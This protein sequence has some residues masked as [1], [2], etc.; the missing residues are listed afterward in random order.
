MPIPTTSSSQWVPSRRWTWS[1]G[2]SSTRVTSYIAEAPSYVGALSTFN[3][4]QA[5]VVHVQMDDDGLIPEHLRN[6]IASVRATGKRAKF[7]YTIPNFHNPAGVSL[8]LSRRRE[9]LEICEE[10]GAADPG[11]QPVRPAGLRRRPLAGDALPRPSVIYLGSFSKTF[12]P[13]FR[14]G[15]AVAPHAVRE[16]LVLAA[17]A[18]VLCPPSFSQLLCRVT[19]PAVDGQQ[20]KVFRELYRER[21]DA[22]LSALRPISR[23]APPGRARGGFY[24]WLTLPEGI[25]AKAMLPRAV[26][27][28][29]AYVSGTASTPTGSAAALRLSYCYPTPERIREGV[30]RLAGVIE[31][32][33]DVMRTFGTPARPALGPAPARNGPQTPS[34]HTPEPTAAIS[35]SPVRHRRAWTGPVD[36]G[37]MLPFEVS[38]GSVSLPESTS[39]GRMWP[40]RHHLRVQRRARCRPSGRS[41]ELRQPSRGSSGATRYRSSLRCADQAGPAAWAWPI[42]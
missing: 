16:K 25:D 17:E 36:G 2:S 7:L 11:G 19:S 21:R 42:T 8:S 27:A 41:W 14:V 40:R 4:Y 10:S 3:S 32:E 30:R 39:R 37:L 24:V 31:E 28:R 12:A 29:V 18:S 6:A 20:I 38:R 9:V 22:M 15:W 13:G 35:G 26:T 23:P 34:P 5:E 33:L 1:P